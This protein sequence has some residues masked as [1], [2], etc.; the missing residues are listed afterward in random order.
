MSANS[1]P[2]LFTHPRF[3][4]SAPSQQGSHLE[5]SWDRTGTHGR[6]DL[7]P[8][9]PAFSFTRVSLHPVC[10]PGCCF[11]FS[12]LL[13]QS[14][15]PGVWDNISCQGLIILFLPEV[16]HT[17]CSPITLTWIVPLEKNYRVSDFHFWASDPS[18]GHLVWCQLHL[19]P[20]GDR[21]VAALLPV[22]PS[23]EHTLWVFRLCVGCCVARK[24]QGPQA[25]AKAHFDRCPVIW[26]PGN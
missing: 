21:K 12:C 8:A 16:I 2:E 18:T 26:L 7:A 3:S 11:I 4:R 19:L 22:M 5:L 24:T 15:L 1:V 20:K 14:P 13:E 6:L 10:R 25:K 23:P 9:E 17:A